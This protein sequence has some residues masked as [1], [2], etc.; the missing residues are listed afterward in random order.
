[1]TEKILE[2]D[3][4]LEKRLRQRIS[5]LETRVAQ[6]EAELTSLRPGVSMLPGLDE[7]FVA[8]VEN[9]LDS[10]GIYTAIR[11]EEGHIV[12]FRIEYVNAA[13]CRSNQMTRAQQVGRG[14]LEILP[15]H[16]AVGLFDGYCQLVESGQP[17]IKEHLIYVDSYNGKRL[18]RA[19]DIRAA[20][21]GDGFV[22]TWRDVTAQKELELALQENERSLRV[23]LDAGQMGMWMWDCA[24]RAVWNRQMCALF[25]IETGDG[26]RHEI[27][28]S[29]A[30]QCMHPDDYQLNLRI[31][32]A[33]MD[34]GADFR[35]E[36]RVIL[37]DNGIRWL[38][39]VGR[40]FRDDQGN[41][42]QIIGVTYDIT[43]RKQME[44]ALRESEAQLRLIIE[45]SR[46]GIHQVDL[47]T[48]RYIFMSPSQETLTGLRL[49]N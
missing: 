9:M 35:Q 1:M 47:L 23:A 28:A 42:A 24:D 29:Q 8:S 12:D 31:I 48:N 32:K 10:L 4:N 15:A 7:R 20:K 22:A 19:F 6:Q 11:N 38:A 30:Y 43:E 44:E 40:L 14:L 49:K 18:E 45:N 21:L 27:D 41:P 16:K 39:N 2:T 33:V 25:G 3:T 26:D 36:L 17:L 46:D 5:E 13:A 37:P 34:T